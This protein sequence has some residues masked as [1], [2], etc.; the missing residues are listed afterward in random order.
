MTLKKI[1]NKLTEDGRYYAEMVDNLAEIYYLSE[2]RPCALIEYTKG[3]MHVNFRS[4][5]MPNVVA[6]I[7]SDLNKITQ[8]IVVEK[9]FA[10]TEDKGIVY[11]DEAMGA[12]YL[13]IFFA[14]QSS[15]LKD[16]ETNNAIFVVK[17]PIPTFNGKRQ[18]RSDKL[19]RKLWGE[20]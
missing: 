20:Q 8:N 17:D 5:L 16:D 4:D 1:L 11:G 18:P 19:Y 12:Y 6:Q 3:L 10:I 2:S 14:L 9:V 7:S 15:S 13:N